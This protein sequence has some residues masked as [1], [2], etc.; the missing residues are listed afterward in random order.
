MGEW[1]SSGEY[2]LLFMFAVLPVP[3]LPSSKDTCMS[4]HPKLATC[5]L[6]ARTTCRGNQQ[7]LTMARMPPLHATTKGPSTE[8]RGSAE[9]QTLSANWG[10]GGGIAHA[11]AVLYL[12]APTCQHIW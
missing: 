10:G 3:I 11:W 6:Q 8:N 1:M 7:G 9:V 12:T 2:T 4:L 5:K